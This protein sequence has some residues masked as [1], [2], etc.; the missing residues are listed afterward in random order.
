MSVPMPKEFVAI[1]DQPVQF[2]DE[3]GGL[4]FRAIELVEVGHTVPQHSH[5][6]DHVTLIASGAAR[7]WVD[8]AYLGEFKGFHALKVEALKK[9]V[10]QA[11]EPHTRLVCVHQ[12]NGAEYRIHEETR[13][14]D[15]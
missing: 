15:H 8:G 6:Y 4:Y 3:V 11:T 13:L 10:F 5:T 1:Q 12:L 9:H 7:V 2:V 14:G